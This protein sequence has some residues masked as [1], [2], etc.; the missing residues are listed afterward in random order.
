MAEVI[1]LPCQWSG[2]AGVVKVKTT[3]RFVKKY[4]TRHYRE[5]HD[6]ILDCDH[7]GLVCSADLFL[8]LFEENY[9]YK[10]VGCENG[11]P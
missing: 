6:D 2:C 1:P 8:S 3:D 10:G 7:A 9:F 11:R 4:C 5:A